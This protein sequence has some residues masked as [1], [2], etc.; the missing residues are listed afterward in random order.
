M[1]SLLNSPASSRVRLG[2]LPVEV[3]SEPANE[4]ADGFSSP[5][6]VTCVNDPPNAANDSVTT[7]ED[8]A[9]TIAVLANDSDQDGDVLNVLNVI[10]VTNPPHV[11]VTIAGDEARYTPDSGF[12][13]SDHENAKDAPPCRRGGI[14]E[15]SGGLDVHLKPKSC[16]FFEGYSLHLAY[17]TGPYE[18][19]HI[20]YG[21]PL[22]LGTQAQEVGSQRGHPVTG[23][24]AVCRDCCQL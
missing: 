3:G 2:S 24:R 7:P 12:S 6:A 11:T 14:R 1:P 21:I 10:S 9:V 8:T 13:G 20:R 19:C 4:S 15:V 17:G 5:A 16:W 18:S 22:S 23:E